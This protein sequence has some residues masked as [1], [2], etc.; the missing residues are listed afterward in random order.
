MEA[1]QTQRQTCYRHPNRETGVSCSNC[2]RPICPE[3][4]TSTPV[5]MRC[6]ECARQTTKVR[7]GAGT[8]GSTAGNMPATYIL[9]GINAIVFLAELLG[10][11]TAGFNDSGSLIRDAGT[12]GPSIADGDWWRVITGGFLHAGLIHLLL[13]MYVL[14]IAGSILEPGVGT[15]R[16]LGIYFVSLLAGSLGALL[17]DPNTVTVGASGAIFGLMA[18]V[19]VVA[20]GRGIQEV[21]SQ[22][23]LFVVLN[24]VL[25]FSIPGISVGGHLG[26]LVGGG[27]AA[28][29]VIFVERQLHG[30][31]GFALELI[32]IV[33][34]IAA[35][36]A[37]A[38]AVA[39]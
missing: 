31:Q 36:F 15:P 12:H 29:L 8:F 5:G 14:Y 33:L 10:G 20:R 27:L 22:F 1:T 34:M 26:G 2:G 25:T 19:I 24:L 37:G 18:A 17:V 11:G 23:G 30:R 3:C 21:A 28:I 39:G 16:F 4:M 35:T 9:I 13:N 7:V 6:P 32:G 38:I